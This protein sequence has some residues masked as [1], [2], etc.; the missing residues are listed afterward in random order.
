M[1]NTVKQLKKLFSSFMINN[2]NESALNSDINKS[3]KNDNMIDINE[4]SKLLKK[5][6]R[7]KIQDQVNNKELTL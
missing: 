7:E 4:M 6:P 3:L 5:Y 2:F 1:F